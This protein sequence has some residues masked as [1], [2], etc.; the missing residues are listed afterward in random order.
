MKRDKK[1]ISVALLLSSL[2]VFH[3]FT[4]PFDIPLQHTEV[5]GLKRIPLSHIKQALNQEPYK[6]QSLLTLK[7]DWIIEELKKNPLVED[8]K[9]QGILLPSPKIRIL[10][11]EIPILAVLD[12]EKEK[13]LFDTRGRGHKIS[14]AKFAYIE[15]LFGGDSIP[16][17]YAKST[18]YSQK[19]LS[20]LNAI[21]Q[22]LEKDLAI[23]GIKEKINSIYYSPNE[24]LKLIGEHFQY[25]IGKLDSASL[26]RVKRLDLALPK[27]QELL[28]KDKID[29][30]YIDLSLTTKD[31]LL[32]KHE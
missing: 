25:K 13:I 8:V 26:A 27:I 30:K 12:L 5:L 6:D 16:K 15:N 2:V 4:K 31:I 29:L 10:I 3:L 32:G 7:R 1:I 22:H 19:N 20:L 21:V 17:I 14:S 11:K 24:N 9:I 23:I 18:F 28:T